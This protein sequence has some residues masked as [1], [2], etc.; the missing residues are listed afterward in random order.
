M[1]GDRKEAEAG[2]GEATCSPGPKDTAASVI[3]SCLS[4]LYSQS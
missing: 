3:D 1:E 4:L 2:Q